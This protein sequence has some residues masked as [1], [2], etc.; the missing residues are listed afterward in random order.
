M[1]DRAGEGNR[2]EAWAAHLVRLQRADEPGTRILGDIAAGCGSA[3]RR[4][5]GQLHGERAEFAHHLRG[6]VSGAGEFVGEIFELGTHLAQRGAR[7]HHV[8]F[9][10][11]KRRPRRRLRPW[12]SGNRTAGAVLGF[13]GLIIELADPIESRAKFGA[14]G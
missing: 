1:T 13:D 7:H 6:D 8:G 14:L 5:E 2:A 12:R 9:T 11:G 3:L 10:D 4:R